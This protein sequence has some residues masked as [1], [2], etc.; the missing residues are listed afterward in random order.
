MQK[1]KGFAG[2]NTS[3]LIEVATKVFVK[4]DQEAQCEADRKMKKKISLQQLQRN[5]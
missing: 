4:R 1:L 5:V 2:K 3:E